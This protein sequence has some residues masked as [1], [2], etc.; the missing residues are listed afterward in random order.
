MTERVG[1]QGPSASRARLRAW[2]TLHGRPLAALATV[3]VAVG[4]SGLS[5]WVQPAL[6]AEKA[7]TVTKQP[8]T[9]TVEEGQSAKFEA[10][11]SGSPAPSVQWEVSTDGGL[12]WGAVP[13]GTANKLTIASAKTSESGDQFRAFFK[14]TA[15]H[16]TS[17]SATLTVH[18]A[19]SVTQQPVG[20]IV[21]EGQSASFE[22]A[23]SG[24]PPPTVQW[25]VS[26]NGGAG[27]SPVAGAT[28]DQLT[29]AE[30]KKSQSGYQYR[31]AFTNVAGKATSVAAT[32]TVPTHNYRVLAW[33]SNAFGQL[34]DGG[35]PF[36]DVPAL[37][38]GV[39]FVSAV[40]AGGR[41]SL[42]L[43]SGGTVMA[44][45][46]G[47]DGQL[48]NGAFESSEAPMLVGGLTQVKA[49]AAGANH[50]LALLSNGT[51][52]AWGDNEAG[53]LGDGNFE[54]AGVPVAVKGLS[55]VTAIAAGGEHS[56]ALLSNGT[57]MAWGDDEY[58]EL[59][60][61]KTGKSNTPVAVKGLSGVGA[62]AA[63]G[64][65][66]LALLSNG[67]VEA[68]GSD[69]Y[70]QLGYKAVIVRKEEE[71]V[72]EELEEEAHSAVPVAI[73][74]VSGVKA[75]AAGARHSVALLSNG[76][77]MA[78]GA[79]S[80]GQLGNGSAASSQPEPV[81][82][83]GLS[84]VSAISAG[85]NDSVA[86]LANG[87]VMTWGDD[88][89]GEL[90]NGGVGG[91]SDI[92]VLVVGLGE[93]SGVSAGTA[94]ELAY[95]EPIPVVSSVSPHVGPTGGETS[96]TITGEHFEE[97]TAVSFGSAAAKSYI[98]SSP[99]SITAVSPPGASGALDVT[100]T[101][102]AGKSRPVS[103]DRFTYLLPPTVKKLSAKKGPGAGHTTITI[104]G[105]GFE[106]ATEVRF[107]DSAAES[108]TVESSTSITAVS[109]PGAGSVD[110]T[111]TAPGGTSPT[112]TKDL[113]QYVPAVEAIAP[114]SGPVAGGTE[115]TITGAGF[116]PGVSTTA[117]KFGS[118][119]ATQVDC[120]SQTSCTALVPADKAGTATVVAS[121]G[122]AKSA[123]GP[124][125][126]YTYE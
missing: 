111:V 31:A 67:T 86:L 83:G 125:D 50:S 114:G 78:W 3:L 104:T 77:A 88:K 89:S 35:S 120:V 16:A 46:A 43:L 123:A 28:A 109:P 60:N 5:P 34:D 81:A 37:A 126:L 91:F 62:I 17:S 27:W 75:I 87:S 15:G 26:I 63:G 55:G 99:T 96:V 80:S 122:K 13:G 117:F 74:G 56:L 14:N 59:G 66:S 24:F 85:G 6:A 124:G 41:H 47:G 72:I 65:H 42:A 23:A 106:G 49:L 102:V 101:T 19:P 20:Q 61:G 110:V 12:T 45:G 44:W 2:P 93:V 18:K 84:G 70:G 82:V 10:A 76:T 25:E 53:Q 52:M 90:G 100:V 36:S 22:A 30:V 11:A 105:T 94:H 121:V 107:G 48:G 118:N 7:P 119:Y 69:E 116:A 1:S 40:S 57:V 98:V 112:S 29:I 4:L 103:A 39:N 92:P 68:W 71:E 21:E 115:V 33:G 113:F 58:G 73:K 79:D 95:G 64:E 54:A 38:S 108:S 51:V 32:L 8:L 97:V 9:V